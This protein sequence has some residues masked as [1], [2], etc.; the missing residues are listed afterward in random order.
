MNNSYSTKPCLVET[1]QGFSVLYNEK[2]LYSKYAPKDSILKIVNNLDILPNT[3]IL[4][5]S[6]V[7]GYGL[8]ELLA[9]LPENCF[10]LALEKDKVLYDFS[11]TES[12]SLVKNAIE[13]INNNIDK[14]LTTKI[15]ADALFISHTHL[16]HAFSDAMNCGIMHYVQIKKIYRAKDLIKQGKAV[17]LYGLFVGILQVISATIL[18][19]ILL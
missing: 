1:R 2:P 16:G 10:I 15:I 18:I 14:P 5:F 3:L 4:C 19:G 13:Y 7:L 9:K 17:S 12:E 6:P 8:E 11:L